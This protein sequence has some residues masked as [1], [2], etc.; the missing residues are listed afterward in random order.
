MSDTPRTDAA[1]FP[2]GDKSWNF[3]VVPADFARELETEMSE[4]KEKGKAMHRRLLKAEGAVAAMK[5][6]WDE[7]GGPRGG[8]FGRAL[9]AAECVRLA[10]G[11]FSPSLCSAIREIADKPELLEVA[12][13]AIENTLRDWRDS[14][15]SE[16]FRGDGL[17]IRAKDGTASSIIR[18]GPETAMRIGLTALADHLSQNGKGEARVVEHPR[19]SQTTP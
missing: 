9:L 4:W 5:R 17:V 16:P 7:H 13:K 12:R 11:D 19:T 15:L 18:F 14:C 6:Q 3:D 2:A 8:S 1:L 10:G